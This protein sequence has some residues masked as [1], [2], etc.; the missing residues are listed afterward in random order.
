MTVLMSV[1]DEKLLYLKQAVESILNQTYHNLEIIIV[2]DFCG[3]DCAGMLEDYAKKDRRIFLIK[4]SQN[5][6]LTKSL[7]TGLKYVHGTYIARMDSDDIS[8]PDRIEQQVRFMERHKD[9]AVCGTLLCNAENGERIKILRY[10]ASMRVRAVRMMLYNAG[11]AHPSA[12]IRTEF[13]KKNHIR[14]NEAFH[15]AQDYALWSEIIYRG[16]KMHIL[17]KVMLKYRMHEGQISSAFHEEQVQCARAVRIQN[18]ERHLNDSLSEREKKR[19]HALAEQILAGTF[20][21]D[22]KLILKIQ[23]GVHGV[24]PGILKKEL[25]MNWWAR[26]IR[27]VRNK[28]GAGAGYFWN[29]YALSIARPDNLIYAFLYFVLKI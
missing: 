1:Y 4:N 22:I 25:L 18:L 10:S 8:V 27:A 17:P 9:V 21:D 12:M 2:D 19:Y 29:R 11:A 14:Y 23:S 28:E 13:L 24:H 20:R 26:G 16:G 7:N 15:R 5:M 3:E 6:G